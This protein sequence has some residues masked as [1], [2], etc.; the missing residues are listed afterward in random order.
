MR[1]PVVAVIAV[2]L[3]VAG[4]AVDEVVARATLEGVWTV[5]TNHPVGKGRAGEGYRRKIVDRDVVAELEEEPRRPKLPQMVD[6]GMEKPSASMA[7]S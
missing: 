3:V 5:V 7:G 1:W 6:E 4:A 2:K